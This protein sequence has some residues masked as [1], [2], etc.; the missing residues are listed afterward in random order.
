MEERA[1]RDFQAGIGRLL[2][3]REGKVA[4]SLR[5]DGLTLPALHLANQFGIGKT[6]EQGGKATHPR[7]VVIVATLAAV[8][9]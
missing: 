1:D 3:V 6:A 8:K 7:A 4:R 2:A 5:L 9:L